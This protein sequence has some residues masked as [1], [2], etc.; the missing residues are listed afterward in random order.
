[1]GREPWSAPEE[2]TR[3]RQRKVLVNTELVVFGAFVGA[4]FEALSSQFSP[5]SKIAIALELLL[6]AVATNRYWESLCGIWT[7]N[8]P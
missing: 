3:E 7:R 1:M 4:Y 5:I 2:S 8:L 6:I